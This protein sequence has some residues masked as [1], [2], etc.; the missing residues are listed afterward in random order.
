MDLYIYDN[1]ILRNTI[2]KYIDFKKLSPK[3]LQIDPNSSNS[4]SNNSTRLIITSVDV[5]T[6]EPLIFDSYKKTY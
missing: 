5:L 2:E 4:N 3:A 1:S 6:A